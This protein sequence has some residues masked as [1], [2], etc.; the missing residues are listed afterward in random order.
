MRI[1]VTGGQPLN[2]TYRPS[3]NPNAAVALIAASLLTDQPVT[4]NNISNTAGTRMMLSL[5]EQMGAAVTR[6]ET[7]HAATIHANKLGKREL[8]RDETNGTVASLLFLAPVLVRRQYVKIEIDFPL[9]RI[10]TH[11][12]ALRNLGLDVVVGSNTIECRPA[13]WAYKDIILSQTSVTATAIVMMLAATLG[14]E[15]V[16]QNAASEPHIQELAHLLER[17]GA[18]IHGTGSNMLRIFGAASLNGTTYDIGPNH[19]ET[20]S[21][22]AISALT[23]GRVT[24]EG[25]RQN[26]LR[27]IDM[28]YQRLGI[29]LDIDENSV[30]I[31]RHAE[32]V[33]SNREEDVDSSIETAPWPGFPSDLVAVAT[34]AATQAR[35]TSLIH[36]KLFN[37]RLLFIDKLNAM[38][39]QIVLCDPHRA[40]VIG[41]APLHAIYMDSPDVRAG[42]GMLAAALIAD[43]RTVIDNAQVIDNAFEGVLRKLKA[44]GAQIEIKE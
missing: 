44:L 6:E 34:V 42:M 32:L 27:V 15:T 14:E 4:L 30:F 24:I 7:K 31:P 38:G 25:T 20:A 10:R 5:C 13:K 19:I 40:I 26:D 21:I 43:G 2:G 23:D 8:T 37:N 33:V 17:M 9:N 35:G 22:A 29:T 39:A 3:G 1:R 11:I 12:E 36:E 28:I 41:P 18:Q 16:I